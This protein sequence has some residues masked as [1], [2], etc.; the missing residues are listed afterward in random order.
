MGKSREVLLKL[1]RMAMGWESDFS[2]PDGIDWKEVLSLSKEQAVSPIVVDGYELYLK[3]NPDAQSFFETDKKLRTMV[4]GT[5]L[6]DRTNLKQAKVLLKLADI[7]HGKQIPFM[8][9][10]GFACARYYPVPERRF[11]G[12]IDI[13]PGDLYDQSNLALKEAGVPVIPYYYRHSASVIN[14]VMIEN[15]RVLG[16]LRGPAR[17]T[18]AFE[19]LLEEEAKQSIRAGGSVQVMGQDI[20]GAVFPSADFNVLFLPWH[21]SAHLAFEKV[22]V[23]QLLDW[24]LFLTH[25]GRQIDIQKFRDAKKRYTYGYSKMAD[26]L[27]NLSL[28]Y[29]KMPE[30]VIP[31]EIAEDAKNTDNCLADR[32]LD[33]MFSGQMRDR[34]RNIWE[35]RWNNVK[36]V[37]RE[38]WKYR[39]IFGLSP[40]GFLWYKTLGAIN[41]VGE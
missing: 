39:D 10:K 22:T 33:Y 1:V 11:C 4:G 30:D 13:Y 7:L 32:V 8:I 34:G 21:V 14:S 41:K 18:Q 29:L 26:V 9:M 36:Q 2:L 15:H 35:A 38:R 28:R 23:R 6:I 20:P 19:A 27:T 3:H 24:A 25:D 40:L 31:G 5:F 16:D 12:D 37:W 17:Q